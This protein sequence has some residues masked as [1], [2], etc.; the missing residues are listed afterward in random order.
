MRGKVLSALD[1]AKDIMDLFVM[2]LL[3]LLT[4]KHFFTE[5]AVKQAMYQDLMNYNKINM[6]KNDKFAQNL[7]MIT[8]LLLNHC[9]HRGH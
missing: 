6:N 2:L 4:F 8:S 3:T 7:L 9:L 1:T 5:L